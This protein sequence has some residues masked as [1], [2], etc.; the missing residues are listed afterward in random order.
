[1]DARE[2]FRRRRED[3]GQLSDLLD[4][5]ER[6]MRALSPEQVQRLGYLYREA[7]ADL[8]LA[9][10]DFVDDRVT[11]FLN[12]LVGRG[13]AVVYQSEPLAWSR[14]RGF[15]ARGFPRTFRHL[16]P[17]TLVAAL[18]FIVPGLLV[19]AATAWQ[20]ALAEQL[21]PA[22]V[23]ELTAMIEEQQLWT[24]I[25]VSERPYVSAFIM[26]NN[27][28]VTFL[29]FAGGMLLGLFTLY[30]LIANGVLIGGL[31]G[32]TVHYGVGLELWTFV[33]SHGVIELSVVFM[34]GGAGLAVGWGIIRPGLLSRRDAVAQAARH[35]IL[36]IMGAAPLLV[37]A[38]L[39][40]G[41]ISPN[42]SIPAAL[43]WAFGLLSGLLLYAYLF[44]SGRR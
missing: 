23:Q 2:L 37:L 39:I 40:E 26:R 21:L 42:E 11:Q 12:Q 25:P 28:R 30:I 8:A 17:F 43:K 41:F 34:A 10:R 31:T 20:P 29:A 6:D 3:W 36:L 5:A 18:A 35:A 44:L 38:G 7:A 9:R 27:I 1:M 4:V 32:L 14:L 16:L 15:I 33:I 22:Q 24:E 19:G 13:H